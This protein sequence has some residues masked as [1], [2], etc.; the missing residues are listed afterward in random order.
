[1]STFTKIFFLINCLILSFIG[2][3]QTLLIN[4]SN[5]GGFELP[6]GLAGNGWS[7]VNSTVN[8]WFVSGDATPF[9]GS[10]LKELVTLEEREQR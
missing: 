6:G 8:N 1:M 7:S 9:L 2:T 5:E 10:N 3:S 4:P